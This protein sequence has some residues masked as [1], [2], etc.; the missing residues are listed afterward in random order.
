M[1]SDRIYLI[2]MLGAA[3]N[4]HIFVDEMT[5]EAFANDLRTVRAVAFELLLEELTGEPHERRIV[6]LKPHL[7]VRASSL[8]G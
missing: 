8:A 2:D 4:I 3:Q 1:K 7:V 5:P 6:S